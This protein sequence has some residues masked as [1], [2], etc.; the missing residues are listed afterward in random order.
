MSTATAAFELRKSVL[1]MLHVP[2]SFR[3]QPIFISF[4][5]NRML[6]SDQ[7]KMNPC[8]AGAIVSFIIPLSTLKCDYSQSS[9]HFIDLSTVL[10]PTSYNS[11]V[12]G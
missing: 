5:P 6:F 2:F 9:F 1:E 7:L 3:L 12:E 4:P 8:L 10:L 11:T